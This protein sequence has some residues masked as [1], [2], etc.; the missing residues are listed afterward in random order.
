MLNLYKCFIKRIYASMSKYTQAL[1]LAQD[2][3]LDAALNESLQEY[4]S[5]AFGDNYDTNLA[6]FIFSAFGNQ[7]FNNLPAIEILS[8]GTLG[9]ANGAFAISTNTIYLSDLFL[10]NASTQQI[11]GVILEE[12]GHWIDSQINIE[13]TQGDEGA[14]FSALLQGIELTPD[15]WQDLRIEDDSAIVTIDGYEVIIEQ[16]VGYLG[17]NIDQI[18]IGIDRFLNF[19]ESSVSRLNQVSLPLIGNNLANADFSSWIQNARNGLAGISNLSTTSNTTIQTTINNR[20]ANTGLSISNVT[21]SSSQVAFDLNLNRSQN[22]SGVTFSENL[23]LNNLPL[24]LNTTGSITPNL[25]LQSSP[26]R[27]TLNSSGLTSPSVTGRSLN[28]GLGLNLS[29]FNVNGNLG[30]LPLN[31]T[32][33]SSQTNNL[34]FNFNVPLDG[35]TFNQPVLNG[36]INLDGRIVLPEINVFSGVNIDL[37]DFAFNLGLNYNNGNLST[38]FDNVALQFNASFLGGYSR[39][40]QNIINPIRPVVDTLSQD[41][42]PLSDLNIFG[43]RPFI[44]MLDQGIGNKDGKVN[45]IDFIYL[46]DIQNGTNYGP[47]VNNLIQI[48]NTLDAFSN[49]GG[50]GTTTVNLGKFTV[51]PNFNPNNPNFGSALTN[52]QTLNNSNFF[53]NLASQSGTNNTFFLNTAFGF[54]LVE[55][56]TQ[57][58]NFLLGQD[59]NLV[60]FQTNLGAN[61]SYDYFISVLGPLGVNIG[62]DLGIGVNLGLGYD[63]RG[64]R[65]YFSSNNASD[66]AQGFYVSTRQNADGTGADIAE[67]IIRGRLRIEGGVDI[68]VAKAF[69]G[70]NIEGTLGFNLIDP[71][72]DGKV[73]IDEFGQFNSLFDAFETTTTLTAG[74]HGRAE[75]GVWPLKKKWEQQFATYTLYDR[76]FS[77]YRPP[78]NPNLAS[79]SGG[80]LVLHTGM[81]A[82]NRA[83]D[84]SGI[85]NEGISISGDVQVSGFG[86]TQN[87]GGV[88]QIRGDGGNGNDILNVAEN[89]QKTI[90]FDGGTGND[91]IN[92][93]ALADTLR[94][95]DGD[96]QL[97]GRGGH[98]RLFGDNGNDTL[99]GDAGNDTLYGGNGHDAL[100]GGTGNDL[101][102]GEAGNDTLYGG[103]GNDTLYGG[104]GNDVLDGGNGNDTLYG[105]DG[106]D[107]LRAGGGV[108]VSGQPSNRLYGGSGNDTLYGSSQQDLL[109]GGSGNDV[110]YGGAGNDIINGGSGDDTLYGEIGN[111][112]INGGFGNDKIYGGEGDDSL[113]G[114]YGNDTLYGGSGN[115]ILRGEQGNNTLYGEAGNDILYAIGGANYLN[116]GYSNQNAN[117]PSG[118]DTYWISKDAGG[119][120]IE[121]YNG[122]FNDNDQV[123]LP[124]SFDQNLDADSRHFHRDGQDL[125]IDLNRDGTFS[126]ASDLTIKN[127]FFRAQNTRTPLYLIENIGHRN[128]TGVVTNITGNTILKHFNIAPKIAGGNFDLDGVDLIPNVNN[129]NLISE[130]VPD[131]GIIDPDVAQKAIAVT[132]FDNNRIGTWEYSTDNGRTWHG[133]PAVSESNAL[134]LKAS[135]RLRF[136]PDVDVIEALKAKAD[137]SWRQSTFQFRAWD[138]TDDFPSGSTVNITKTGGNS[139]FSSEVATGKVEMLL[140]PPENTWSLEIK[141]NQDPSDLQKP[142][143]IILHD[144]VLAGRSVFLVGNTTG[145]LWS[146]QTHF[147]GHNDIWLTQVDIKTGERRPLWAIGTQY[148]DT[149]AK[150]AW[151]QTDP[152]TVYVSYSAFLGIDNYHGQLVKL[153]TRTGAHTSISVTNTTNGTRYPVDIATDQEGNIYALFNIKGAQGGDL[154]PDNRVIVYN[155]NLQQIGSIDFGYGVVANKIHVTGPDS[156]GVAGFRTTDFVLSSYDPGYDVFKNRA[157]NTRDIYFARINKPSGQSGYSITQEVE[158]IRYYVSKNDEFGIDFEHIKPDD[159]V[160]GLY[161]KDWSARD[162]VYISTSSGVFVTFDHVGSGKVFKPRQIV[163][164]LSVDENDNVYVTGKTDV[165][166]TSQKII[167]GSSWITKYE[168]TTNPALTFQSASG[169][170]HKANAQGEAQNGINFFPNALLLDPDD[171]LGMALFGRATTSDQP[172]DVSA[173]KNDYIWGTGLKS[174]NNAPVLVEA[175]N[176]P[177]LNLIASLG[178]GSIYLDD[179]FS[180]STVETLVSLNSS[181]GNYSYGNPVTMVD[182]DGD[183]LGIAVTNV[184]N[185]N[186]D[187][188]FSNDNGTSWLSSRHEINLWNSFNGYDE[189]SNNYSDIFSRLLGPDVRM[190]FVPDQGYIGESSFQFRLWDMTDQ[191]DRNDFAVSKIGRITAH[192]GDTPYSSG[193]GT[194]KVEI[195]NLAPYLDTRSTLEISDLSYK[196][197]NPVGRTID[198]LIPN[199]TI[200]DGFSRFVPLNSGDLAGS[201]WIQYQP[202]SIALISVDNSN[203]KWQ[204]ATNNDNWQDVGEVSEANARL[205][206]S[207]HKIRF[208]PNSGYLGEASF[209]FRAWDQTNGNGGETFNV[210]ATGGTTPFSAETRTATIKVFNTAPVLSLSNNA[211]LPS[212]SHNNKESTGRTVAQIVP[213]GVITDADGAIKAIAVTSVNDS[214]GTWQYSTNNGESWLNF[215]NVSQSQ[216]RLLQNNHRIRFIPNTNFVGNATFNFKAWDG[217]IGVAGSTANTNTNG[218]ETPFSVAN[219][220]ARIAITNTAPVLPD[221]SSILGNLTSITNKNIIPLGNL[222]ADIIPDNVITDKDGNPQKSIALTAI[223]NN[224]GKWQYSLDF[225]ETWLN[226]NPVSETSA[227]LLDSF[228][229]IRFLPNSNFVGNAIFSFRAW[230]QRT[231]KVGRYVNTSS[232]GGNTAFSSVI[233]N[234]RIRI[235]ALDAEGETILTAFDTGLNPETKR[236]FEYTG[237][238]GNNASKSPSRDVD[239]YKIQL[240]QGDVINVKVITGDINS[241]LDAMIEFYNSQGEKL[242]FSDKRIIFDP[243]AENPTEN[244]EISNEPFLTLTAPE[245]GDYYI[246]VSAS[247]NES[248]SPFLEESPVNINPSTSGT[249]KLILDMETFVEIKAVSANKNEGHSGTTPFTFDVIRTGNLNIANSVE[250]AVT[251]SGANRAD[252]DDFANGIFPSGKIDFAVGEESKRIT[253]RVRG[254]LDFEPDEQ[255]TVRLS[256]PSNGAIITTATARGT[257]RNDEILVVNTFNN[258]NAISIVDNDQ[259]NPY[260]SAINVSGLDGNI[261]KVQVVLRNISHSWAKDIDILLVSPTGAKSLVMSD[262]GGTKALNKV[263]LTIDPSA[264]QFLSQNDQ[265]ITG[266]YKPTDFETNDIFKSPAPSGPYKADFSIF[267]R[268]NP[269]G[270]W[271]LYVMD[272]ERIASGTIQGGWSLILETTTPIIIPQINLSGNQTVVEG[273]TSPQNVLYTVTLSEPGNQNVSV[274]YSTANGTA[275]AG[276]DYTATNGTLTFLPGEITKT[277]SIPIL[278][279]SIN[280]PNET[281]TLRLTNP[282]NS[283][284]GRAT[285][286]TTITDTVFADINT[287][288]RSNVENLTLT[289][290]GNINGTGNAGNN[291]IQGNSGNNRLNGG[292]GNDTLNGGDGN[293]TL[294]GGTGADRMAGGKGNDTYYVDNTGD[295]VIE[296]LNQGTDTVRS[297]ITYTLPNHVE[298][299]ILEGT[300]NI[301]GSGNSLN[302]VITGN[303]GNNILNGGTGADTLRGGKGNDTYYVDNTGDRVI[304]NANEGIDTVRSNITYTLPNH[305]E[306]LILEGTGNING[307]GNTL[308][309]RITGNSDNNR[310]NG[311]DGNDTLNGGNG[312]DTLNGGTG[313]DRMVG[314][315]GDDTYYVDNAND[316]VVEKLNEGIDTVIST[317]TYTLPNHVE[318]LI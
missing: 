155:S 13:D 42:K 134:L 218:G 237:A 312:N 241:P 142:P 10:N 262:V 90:Y 174:I 171:R 3:L 257:I 110:V 32:K 6:T 127:F 168:G 147:G 213:N 145:I 28:V 198:S 86:H 266:T 75:I 35:S 70:G 50:S 304:E 163:T 306:N 135:D 246:R 252:K 290:T 209:T 81:A 267:N 25:S 80:V 169:I 157:N 119:T 178:Y 65:R 160:T 19:L 287:T 91:V 316:I 167:G 150:I 23:G 77:N 141:S 140:E 270:Q 88:N 123:W 212:I 233:R 85:I 215:G 205:L 7:S 279:D 2:F 217:S 16:N 74:L 78:Y 1:S 235:T 99:H 183:V 180:Y 33:N 159:I 293:D 118:N 318:N 311:G 285:A 206:N 195:T 111:D 97:Y 36:G 45:F 305:V 54:P 148:S 109:D 292:E 224:N 259:S 144:A 152:D 310:L 190:R 271:N 105:G 101:L 181:V 96:D 67:A 30:F 38:N 250:W 194:V 284:L 182:Y 255:F 43:E 113:L 95:G 225:G 275:T 191:P 276:A 175:I 151:S 83:S 300:G 196:N 62:A 230:D 240:N 8:S 193:I 66:L 29:T 210:S 207:E 156:F 248:P 60:T 136:N 249:Y 84:I 82:G 12:I 48:F 53:S 251:G 185:T 278:N 234:A 303:N 44:S 317:I 282:F 58:F 130:I 139:A 162:E 31:L 253:V 73:R 245:T 243:E 177:F 98:D 27:F 115:D 226:I 149:R 232:N 291:I 20:L 104:T 263:T 299:L 131:G 315:K 61:F 227:L 5:L 129:G 165:K 22:I 222:I 59:L 211:T 89:L 15:E 106:H 79:V 221:S 244:M 295:R 254:D 154:K 63:T 296:V 258:N 236:S 192:G 18:L 68:T 277:I 238:I 72:G 176:Y 153:N 37:P 121:D 302:N 216:A 289:G 161:T 125:I 47:Q 184:D 92:G 138:R 146:G 298:N 261:N 288:L 203:G 41:I 94:G 4:L 143:G 179:D 297:N 219:G 199:H 301:N 116:G 308:A 264:S 273:F 269:N 137:R 100:H 124:F 128:S 204:F 102:Y 46:A 55:N 122:F 112:T 17:G 26:F 242:G 9:N 223:N 265:I 214:N 107:I 172:S 189:R 166:D 56:P 170:W 281:F 69:I 260:P 239:F 108:T 313:A 231:G 280:E 247:G 40:I 52:V 208:V 126:R 188:Q 286:T 164:G 309:N 256:N 197:T 220:T 11:A 200:M 76:T 274:Q 34:N 201:G 133:V 283:T 49:L 132:Y 64:L 87:F 117:V 307:T 14:I 114:G 39:Y 158:G 57:A 228:S 51:N 314:G 24:K 120:V 103:D 21:L 187:W 173:H 272:D 186:G 229:R 294:I 268:T 71:D 202:K 93:G